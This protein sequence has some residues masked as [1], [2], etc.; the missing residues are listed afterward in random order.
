MSCQANKKKIIIIKQENK[1]VV[2][3]AQ[4]NNIEKTF[5]YHPMYDYNQFDA[6]APKIIFIDV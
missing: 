6:I 4:K 5:E 2:L 3:S 1:R